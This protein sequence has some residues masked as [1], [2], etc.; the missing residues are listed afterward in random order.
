MR[1]AVKSI[2]FGSLLVA[3]L[4]QV[5]GCVPFGCGAYDGASD[6]VYSRE[7][8]EMLIVCGNG[9]F[10]ANLQTTSIEGR[11]EYGADGTAIGVKGDDAS[12]AFDWIEN[13]DGVSTPQLGGATWTYQNLDKTALDHADVLCQDL[14]T[15]AWWAQ[16]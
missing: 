6:R 1:N 3:P 10:V 4:A 14:E 5:S 8:A 16:Q 11:M 9:G 13:A 2:V 7:G 15:R 12:L